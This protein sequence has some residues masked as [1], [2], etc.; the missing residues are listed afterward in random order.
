MDRGADVRMA[1]AE[2][3]FEQRLRADGADQRDAHRGGDDPAHTQAASES[4]M[5]LTKHALST[6]QPI[7]V[8]GK[9]VYVTLYPPTI[10]VDLTD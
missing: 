1:D 8:P 6:N 9:R 7:S 2:P 4:S 5:N 3:P 10:K